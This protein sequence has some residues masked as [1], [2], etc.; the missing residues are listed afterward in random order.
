[1]SNN[2]LYYKIVSLD[3]LC[4]EEFEQLLPTISEQR[5]EK[6][7]AYKFLSGR[8]QSLLAYVTLKNLLREHY[9]IDENPILQELHNGKPVIVGHRGIHFSIS[10]CNT[11][12]ACAVSDKPVGIDIESIDRKANESLYSYTL[13]Q[14]EEQK[15]REA[16]HPAMEFLRY[17][18]MKEALVKMTGD[19]ISGKEQLQSLL[20]D[21]KWN[22]NKDGRWNG[23]GL[24]EEPLLTTDKYHI[25]NKIQ[26][27]TVISICISCS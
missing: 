8:K 9:S 5:R 13:N 15:V 26:N 2:P 10:H 23:N 3:S 24:E 4:D 18:T 17:W 14:A 21:G 1:M 27:E 12:V 11:A 19:G 25:Y 16:K 20:K 7:M 6:V 22:E